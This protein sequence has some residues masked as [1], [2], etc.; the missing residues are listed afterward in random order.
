MNLQTQYLFD[1]SAMTWIKHFF[2]QSVPPNLIFLSMTSLCLNFA[3]FLLVFEPITH[4][5]MCG[6]R[7]FKTWVLLPKFIHNFFK[8]LKLKYS[9][10]SSHVKRHCSKWI[11][12][13]IS[14]AFKY[15]MYVDWTSS[16]FSPSSLSMNHITVVRFFQ[17]GAYN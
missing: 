2:T 10:E 14:Y 8:R 9:H 17:I 5:R 6:F 16:L 7:T 1:I 13:S 4:K 12:F 15:K 3:N 11:A